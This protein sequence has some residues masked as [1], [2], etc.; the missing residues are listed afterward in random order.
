MSNAP[1]KKEH[2]NLA[3]LLVCPLVRLFAAFSACL[4]GCLPACLFVFLPACLSVSLP[5]RL[6]VCLSVC[7]S[8]CPF[9]SPSVS[10]SACLCL[11]TSPVLQSKVP[12][13][14]AQ[15]VSVSSTKKTQHQFDH[16]FAGNLLPCMLSHGTAEPLGLVILWHTEVTHGGLEDITQ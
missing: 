4:P 11:S 7:L 16:Y 12:G 13:E 3:C 1:A 10:L 14:I 15:I 2:T 8:A 6:S 5:V 9:A